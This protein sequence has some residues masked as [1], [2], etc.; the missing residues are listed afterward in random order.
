MSAPGE[1][2]ADDELC[3][4]DLLM[5]ARLRGELL[6]LRRKFRLVRRSAL[7]W[8]C[9][10][11]QLC[12]TALCRRRFKTTP[13]SPEAVSA[14]RKLA[15]ELR[16]TLVRLGPT[17]IKVGQLLSTRVDVLPP[18]VIDELT[19]LQNDVPGFPAERAVA[20]IKQELGK[21]PEELF[22]SFERTPLAAASL[23]Q[24]HRA[25]LKTGEEV[26]VKVQREN[27]KELFDIDLANIRLVA[28][29]ADRLD[30]QTEATSANWKGI[31]DTSGEVRAGEAPSGVCRGRGKGR[32]RG[33]KV[34]RGAAEGGPEPPRR[35][36][37]KA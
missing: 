3:G 6:G 7:I 22:A 23:A 32:R 35:A 8:R 5:G 36:V 27:L 20:L 1:V 13:T 29:L 25:K 19:R 30:P 11:V 17:F 21:P 18:E 26:V 24:V 2:C 37:G 15:G 14:R 4:D 34:C 10:F 16:D 31:A 12:K 9:V 28:K 33:R